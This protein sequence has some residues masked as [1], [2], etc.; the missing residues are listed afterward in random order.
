[1][2]AFGT[3]IT[4]IVGGAVASWLVYLSLDSVAIIAHTG[5][6]IHHRAPSAKGS[7]LIFPKFVSMA[8]SSK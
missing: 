3:S 6:P 1:M 2:P 5:Y 7:P 4:G 8:I